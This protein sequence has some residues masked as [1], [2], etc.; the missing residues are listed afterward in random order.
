MNG[1]S[2][3][4]RTAVG[5][6]LIVDKLSVA[7]P[8]AA[9]ESP[10]EAWTT[11]DLIAH[12]SE[13][14]ETPARRPEPPILPPQSETIIS[15]PKPE[16]IEPI[17]FW[18]VLER[19]RTLYDYG[20]PI[21]VEQVGALLY[22]AARVQATVQGTLYDTTLRPYPS[23]GAAYELEIY[24]L[25]AAC[26][27]LDAGFYHYRP[28]A[29]AFE[30]LPL[31][32]EHAQTMMDDAIRQTANQIDGVQMALYITARMRR[33]NWKNRALALAHQNTGVLIQTL[34]L[35]AA[36]LDLAPCALGGVDPLHFSRLTGISPSEEPLTGGF[37]VG[38]TRGE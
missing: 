27:G 12:F 36:A 30:P 13:R 17:S 15:L 31:S 22:H 11:P 1:K 33:I 24:A 34:Y 26:D 3:F 20:T 6:R 37:L 7:L 5:W 28:D 25:A 9:G 4:E 35:T 19:R 16:S 23:A 2:R 21:R 14:V 18:A 29:H 38:S 10:H 32:D 8:A